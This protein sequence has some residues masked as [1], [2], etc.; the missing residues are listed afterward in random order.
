MIGKTNGLGPE[1]RIKSF[2][3]AF[4]GIAVLLLSQPNTW[5]HAMA[6]L[7]S[8][9]AGFYFGIT[10]TEWC[11]VVISIFMV[12][13]AEALNTALEFM[14]DALSTD[15]NEL[16]GRAKDVSAAAVLIASTG[17]AFIG[18]IVFIPYIVTLLK[19]HFTH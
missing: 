19:T 12:W 6:T 8:C 14:G 18:V 3:Y 5:I 11:F 13:T 2:R 9:G 10:R 4:R 1:D 17:A 15:Y 7:V 16:I